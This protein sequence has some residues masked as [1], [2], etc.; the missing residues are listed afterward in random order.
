MTDTLDKG[1]ER[2]GLEVADMLDLVG[3]KSI[4]ECLDADKGLRGLVELALA[5]GHT[6]ECL[7]Y[8]AKTARAHGNFYC[9]AKC[10]DARRTALKEWA[11]G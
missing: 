8:A 3:A 11:D 9:I 2:L 4:I 6:D 1:C 7:A 10:A 5:G